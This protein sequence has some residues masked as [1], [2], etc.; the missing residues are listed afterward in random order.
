[1]ELE[2]WDL[3]S[4]VF[5]GNKQSSLNVFST[6]ITEMGYLQCLR[7]S[8][9]QLKGKHCQKTH[10]CNGVVDTFRHSHHSTFNNIKFRPVLE[11][12]TSFWPMKFLFGYHIIYFTKL[13]SILNFEENSKWFFSPLNQTTLSRLLSLCWVLT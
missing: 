11:A 3:A 1:M 8:V 12:S 2:T 7:F 5:Y 9:V 13:L 6:P 4:C 10:C